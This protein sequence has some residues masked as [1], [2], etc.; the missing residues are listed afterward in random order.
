MPVSSSIL[1][2]AAFFRACG[3]VYCEILSQEGVASCGRL[4]GRG[5]EISMAVLRS[6]LIPVKVRGLASVGAAS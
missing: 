5:T 6:T 3:L 4:A 1:E 2:G